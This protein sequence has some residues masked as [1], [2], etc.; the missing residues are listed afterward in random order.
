MMRS[1]LA[2]DSQ[3]FSIGALEIRSPMWCPVAGAKGHGSPNRYC[4]QT[5]ERRGDH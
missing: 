2:L 4:G 1:G 3:S 5:I